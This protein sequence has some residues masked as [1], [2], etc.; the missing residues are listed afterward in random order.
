MKWLAGAIGLMTIAL[1]MLVACKK[2]PP[3]G[4]PDAEPPMRMLGTV[5]GPVNVLASAE[6]EPTASGHLPPAQLEHVDGGPGKEKGDQISPPVGAGLPPAEISIGAI[7]QSVP[8]SNAERIVAGMRARF[9]RCYQTA[10]R[11]GADAARKPS[12]TMKLSIKV[13]ADGAVTA[14]D[15]VENAG[16]PSSVV[17][18]IV[19]AAKL[20]QFDPPEGGKTSTLIVPLR[21]DPKT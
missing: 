4:P 13:G 11:D 12:G 19:R 21:M 5:G 7:A 1:A 10:L 6:P 20:A 2:D 17:D 3:P 18:C 14:S 9:R 16:L 8:I 15:A